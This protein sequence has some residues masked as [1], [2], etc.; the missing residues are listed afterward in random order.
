MTLQPEKQPLLAVAIYRSF[1]QLENIQRIPRSLDGHSD[2][3]TI[4]LAFER[5]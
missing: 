4:Q 2:T 5:V 1:L 3:D